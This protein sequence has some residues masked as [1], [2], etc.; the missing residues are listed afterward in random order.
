LLLLSA[1][2]KLPSSFKTGKPRPTN[3]RIQRM[4]ETK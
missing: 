3:Q 4:E 2:I 1:D